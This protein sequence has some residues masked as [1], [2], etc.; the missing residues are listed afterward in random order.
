MLEYRCIYFF[1]QVPGPLTEEMEAERR[2]REAERKRVQKKAKQERD[3][4]HFVVE[5]VNLFAALLNVLCP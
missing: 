4:V 3:K 5:Y 1:N 2:K